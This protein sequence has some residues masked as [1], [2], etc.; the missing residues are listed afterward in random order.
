MPLINLT[1]SWDEVWLKRLPAAPL[2]SGAG[3]VGLVGFGLQLQCFCCKLFS[4][5][6][7]L[8]KQ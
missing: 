5:P 7:I 2:R 6:E 8:Q 3:V 4:H 1:Q